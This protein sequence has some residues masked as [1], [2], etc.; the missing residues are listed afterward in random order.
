MRQRALSAC[1]LAVFCLIPLVT[2]AVVPDDVLR[3]QI[4]EGVEQIQSGEGLQIE[5]SSVAS[6][7]VLPAL[8]EQR[9]FAPVWT[10]QNSIKQLLNA[11]R[12]IDQDGLDPADYHLDPL[13]CCIADSAQARR[14]SRHARPISICC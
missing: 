5:G 14:R 6:Q 10:N 4:R 11:L 9:G 2:L 7:I 12:T 3:E 8:Y 13:R 1:I